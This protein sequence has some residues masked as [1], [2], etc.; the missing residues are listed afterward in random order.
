[1]GV[2]TTAR[3]KGNVLLTVVTATLA[4]ALVTLHFH[5]DYDLLAANGK[6]YKLTNAITIPSL[7]DDIHNLD[8]LFVALLL[9]HVE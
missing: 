5:A 6:T 8:M 9:L 1:M 7:N 2:A 3:G 4:L